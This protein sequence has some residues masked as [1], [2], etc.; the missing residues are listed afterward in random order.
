ML[1]SSLSACTGNT[2]TTKYLQRRQCWSIATLHK[3]GMCS[4]T[5]LSS[6]PTQPKLTHE[7]CNLPINKK[8]HQN[9]NL[10]HQYR[11][12]SDLTQAPK[13]A[14]SDSKDLVREDLQK[15]IPK[16]LK[17]NFKQRA[18]FAKKTK[19]KSIPRKENSNHVKDKG[20][21]EL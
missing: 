1:R 5:L 21:E 6:H 3:S 12:R 15:E 13:N 20:V 18:S 4:V 8:Q 2:L 11:G 10:S 14:L 16:L 19:L 7:Y 17:N 9:C